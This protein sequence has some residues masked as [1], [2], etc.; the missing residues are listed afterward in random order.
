VTRNRGLLLAGLLLALVLAGGVSYYASSSP[1]GLAKVADDAGF[2]GTA[3]DSPLADSPVAD[4]EVRGVSDDRLAGGLAGV[5]GVLATFAVG[6]LVFLAVRRSA[7]GSG[8]RSGR[9]SGGTEPPTDRAGASGD[10]PGPSTDRVGAPTGP[11]GVATEP[12]PP[13][14]R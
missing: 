9:G 12:G 4:Y 2:A 14:E 13:A 8:G 7:R 10:G 5:L 1:D 6:G 11:V 3:E